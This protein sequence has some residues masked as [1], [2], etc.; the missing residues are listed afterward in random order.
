MIFCLFD[1]FLTHRSSFSLHKYKRG[2]RDRDRM[3]VPVQSV[4]IA[5][6][7]PRSWR[8]VLDITLCDQVCR[9][10]VTGRWF[11]PGTPVFS[12]NKADHHD[13]CNFVASGVKHHKP[14]NHKYKQQT[15]FYN[16]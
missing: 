4:P 1:D 12:T 15:S 11:S 5:T 10:F 8:D 9:R 6:K 3:V 14:T 16:M 7:E 13:D 2:R